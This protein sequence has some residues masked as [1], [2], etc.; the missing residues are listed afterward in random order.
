MVGKFSTV[1]FDNSEEKLTQGRG[2]DSQAE[3][4]KHLN[5]YERKYL[6]EVMQAYD[7][8][9]Q[10]TNDWLRIANCYQLSAE[11]VQR[12]KDYAFGSGV[13]KNK[14]SPDERMVEAWHR[15]ALGEGTNID[16]VLLRHEIF[17]SNLVI[18]QGMNQKNAH[19]QAQAI[20]PWSILIQQSK[21]Q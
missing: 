14:F 1:L 8:I 21:N 4:W 6:K 11:E 18:N 5:Q 13:S 16:E 12:A 9:V 17:E 15:M 3:R 10:D 19:D 7:K 2:Q 20:Y